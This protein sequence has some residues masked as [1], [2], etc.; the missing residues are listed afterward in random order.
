MARRDDHA[1]RQAFARLVEQ[2]ILPRLVVLEQ[3]R[4]SELARR[5]FRRSLAGGIA[6]GLALL[7]L[8]A[9]DDTMLA[10]I[11]CAFI[12]FG[13]LTA[14]VLVSSMSQEAFQDRVRA[15]IC[16]PIAAFL[17][18]RFDLTADERPDLEP[19]KRSALLPDHDEVS[20][21]NGLS[22]Q[23]RGLSVS[24][25]DLWLSRREQEEDSDG[26]TRWT[27]RLVFQGIIVT[28]SLHQPAPGRIVFRGDGGTVLNAMSGFFDRHFKGLMPVAIDHPAFEA[29]FEVRAD[30]PEAARAYIRGPFLE[31]L[32][33]FARP[34]GGKPPALAAAF[35]EDRFLLAV[36]GT[37]IVAELP[38]G[39]SLVD[40]A[41]R[42]ED[43]RER[44]HLPIRLVDT[45]LG[46][47]DSLGND[48]T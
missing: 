37:S 16:P 33:A 32:L 29:A 8:L 18:L 10:A 11:L 17:G 14:F 15:A 44:M 45:F 1:S 47:E 43:M 40:S 13:A 36:S 9:I 26:K 41:P 27:R 34:E 24:A 2:E 48:P 23:Y 20:F 6:A 21:R 31:A 3:E 38:L 25:C 35:V 5:R 19:F 46:P 30:H 28:L 12:A 7:A 4:Q 39:E 42:L 22:G